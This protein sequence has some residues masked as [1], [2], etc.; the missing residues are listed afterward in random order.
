VA[1]MILDVRGLIN[2]IQIKNSV[3]WYWNVQPHIL[4]IPNGNIPLGDE[5]IMFLLTQTSWLWKGYSLH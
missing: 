5:Q 1:K 2:W 3:K 4:S